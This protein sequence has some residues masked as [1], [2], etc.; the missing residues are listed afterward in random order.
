MTSK[1]SKWILLL[2]AILTFALISPIRIAAQAQQSE[3]T[4]LQQLND[5]LQQLEQE[6]R[7]LKEQLSQA[8]SGGKSQVTVTATTVPSEAS[9]PNEQKEQT[10]PHEAD[11]TVKK[12]SLDIYGFVM[13]DSGYDFGQTDPNWFDVE[14]PTRL[15]SF[16]NEFAPS[17]NVYAGVRQTRFGVKSSTPTRFGDL[18]TLF[19]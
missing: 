11:E 9:A 18:K 17:G 7:Q 3:S 10:V 4:N 16:S 5:K 1:W 6:V 14:R 15:P 8:E 19:E 12:N 2:S 13:L